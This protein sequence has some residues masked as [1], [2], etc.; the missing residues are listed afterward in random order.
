[1]QGRK[2]GRKEGRRGRRESEGAGERTWEGLDRFMIKRVC[3][4][5]LEIVGEKEGESD[6]AFVAKWVCGA[7]SGETRVALPRPLPGDVRPRL[8]ATS[9]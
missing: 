5:E 1:M 4:R 6:Y 3:E 9:R 2:E 7:F 8:G